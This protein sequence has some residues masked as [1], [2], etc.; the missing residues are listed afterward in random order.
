[1]G[2]I[3]SI[4]PEIIEDEDTAGLSHEAF[5]LFVGLIALADDYGNMRA[6]PNW[7]GGQIFWA[8]KGNPEKALEELV[9]RKLVVL[10]RVGSES[11]AHIRGWSKHQRVDKPGTPRVPAFCETLATSQEIPG[12]PRDKFLGNSGMPGLISDQDQDLDP[13]QDPDP[14]GDKDPGADTLTEK[15]RRDSPVQRVVAHYRGLHPS[16]RPGDKDRQRIRARLK[17]GYSV[18]DLIAAIDG[19]HASPWHQ[20][21]NKDRKK[22][23]SLELAMRDSKHVQDFMEIWRGRGAGDAQDAGRMD[24]VNSLERLL[25]EDE[26]TITARVETEEDSEW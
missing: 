6:Q 19:Q 9:S 7:L 18:E 22:Y 10:Y 13:D 2:R 1:M 12:I 8:T 15:E 26:G 11:Y 4:K 21:R 14:E 17:E 20:G 16:S 24:F 23:L 3:R 5:R 25:D